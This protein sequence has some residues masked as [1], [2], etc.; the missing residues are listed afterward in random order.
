MNKAK[1]KHST[2]GHDGRLFWRDER[3]I[4]DPF[5]DSMLE[6]ARKAHA[7]AVAAYRAYPQMTALQGSIVYWRNAMATIKWL[8]RRA[9]QTIKYLPRR[10]E[11]ESIPY[12]RF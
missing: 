10:Y 8:Q 4:I 2:K 12:E 1:P 5:L 9:G 6:E 7:E 11:G 3:G